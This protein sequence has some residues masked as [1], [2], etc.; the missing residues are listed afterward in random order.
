MVKIELTTIDLIF[1]MVHVHQAKSM[2]LRPWQ[3]ENM[4]GVKV[5]GTRDAAVHIVRDEKSLTAK[6]IVMIKI[7]K[8]CQVLVKAYQRERR[9]F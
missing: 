3:L 5:V 2:W 7:S 6:R 1:T 8:V 4:Q 9:L